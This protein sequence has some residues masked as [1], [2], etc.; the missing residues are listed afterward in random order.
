MKKVKA[1]Q[2]EIYRVLWPVIFTVIVVALVAAYGYVSARTD[3][4]PQ[5]NFGL[6]CGVVGLA[7]MV[8]LFLYSARKSVYTLKVGT[9]H[10]WFLAHIYLSIICVFLIFIHS[11]FKATGLFT[12]ILLTLFIFVSA[13][14]AVGLMMYS[15]IPFSLTK[16]GSDIILEDEIKA[17]FEKCLADSDKIAERSS[18]HFKREYR[19]KIRPMLLPDSTPWRYLLMEE[20]RII[21]NI[22]NKFE[23]LRKRVPEEEGYDVQILGGLCIQRERLAFKYIKLNVLKAWLDFHIP[24]TVMLGTAVVVHVITIF[25]F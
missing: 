15:T 19:S 25:Y 10:S 5:T 4:I 7:V 21:A 20:Q 14:G 1:T 23:H 2:A 17:K 13:S 9:T 6:W 16:F 22:E 8:V 11:G 18:D 3:Y 12:G 24:F